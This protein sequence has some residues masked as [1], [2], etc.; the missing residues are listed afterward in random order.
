MKLANLLMS[1]PTTCAAGIVL[2]SAILFITALIHR[3]SS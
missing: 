3:S 1:N 2:A